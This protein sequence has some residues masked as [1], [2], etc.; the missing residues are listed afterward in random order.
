[1]HRCAR[2]VG[3]VGFAV[4]CVVY[5]LVA[6]VVCVISVL[7]LLLLVALDAIVGERAPEGELTVVPPAP[8]Q[9]PV[10]VSIWSRRAA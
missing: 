5:A 10:A 6:L 8:P 4:W 9:Q 1:M 2:A 7:P 3:L